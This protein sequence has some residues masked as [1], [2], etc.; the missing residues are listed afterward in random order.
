MAETRRQV[1]LWHLFGDFLDEVDIVVLTE[2]SLN[3]LVAV[4]LA[5]YDMEPQVC[6]WTPTSATLGGHGEVAEK[7]QFLHRNLQK[8][9]LRTQ[10]MQK[11]VRSLRV[12]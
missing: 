2:I 3:I 1:V 5:L 11:N 10:W 8:L 12:Y 9:Q 6:L 4:L 7:L